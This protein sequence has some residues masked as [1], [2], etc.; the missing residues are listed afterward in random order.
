MKELE[1]LVG[2]HQTNVPVHL[3]TLRRAGLVKATEDENRDW[4]ALA[5][6][7]VTDRGLELVGPAD[8][9]ADPRPGVAADGRNVNR[10]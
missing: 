2:A 3:A 7:T 5:C 9:G 8:R 1:E 10:Q 6:G 4:Q